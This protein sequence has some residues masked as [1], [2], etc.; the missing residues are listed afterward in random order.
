MTNMV[1]Q[2]RR[3]SMKRKDK[4]RKA[5]KVTPPSREKPNY[6]READDNKRVAL[7]KKR[8]SK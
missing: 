6:M 5:P 4:P 2:L 1:I 8:F 7:T 3:N